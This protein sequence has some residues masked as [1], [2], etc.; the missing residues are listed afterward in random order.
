[1]EFHPEKCSSIRISKSRNPIRANYTLK[2]HTLKSENSTRYLGVEVQSNL[3]WNKHIDQTVRKA[4]SVLGFLRRN[5]RV[6]NEDTKT[7]A[8]ISMMRPI[9]EYS[10]TVWNPYTKANIRKLE[11]VKVHSFISEEC[12]IRF[13]H[14]SPH[15]SI[16]LIFS[17]PGTKCQVELLGQSCVRRVSSVVRRP[18]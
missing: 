13:I 18:S 3:S 4:N 8:Y 9:L 16:R 10:A 7:A 1:M 5:L 12:A 11:M 6:N 14:S 15:F 2:G 17:S